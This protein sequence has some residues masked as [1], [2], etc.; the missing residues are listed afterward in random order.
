MDVRKPAHSDA[1]L[2]RLLATP[3]VYRAFASALGGPRAARRFVRDYLRLEPGCRVLDLGCG[4]GALVTHL[5]DSMGEYCGVD[6]NAAYIDAARTRW[7][8]RPNC[9]FVCQQMGSTSAPAR[10]HYDV[11]VALAVLH[12]LDDADAQRLF[13]VA[14]DA[15]RS[16]GR[17]VTYD[18]VFVE[19][20]S[21]VAQWL[22][23]RDRGRAV[24]TV[25]GYRGLAATRFTRVVDE[26]LDDTLNVPYTVLV[27]TGTK[28]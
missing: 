24:R 17:V 18:P 28:A 2:K 7:Q 23:S 12:H 10:D 22:I 16:G 4:P 5:P 13:A 19:G 11:V 1:G 8:G 9:T 6:V 15:L 14:H 20:Q 3:W 21:R 27:M 26:V 25:D